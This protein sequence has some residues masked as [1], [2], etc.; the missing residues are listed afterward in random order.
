MKQLFSPLVAIIFSRKYTIDCT[1]QLYLPHMNTVIP[2]P[3]HGE[4]LV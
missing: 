4:Y 2:P 3:K 1:D